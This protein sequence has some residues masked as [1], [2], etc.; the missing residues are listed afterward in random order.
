MGSLHCKIRKNGGSKELHVSAGREATLN[1]ALHNKLQQGRPSTLL[2]YGTSMS[3]GAQITFDITRMETLSTFLKRGV[4]GDQLRFVMGQVKKLIDDCV[5]AGLPLMNLILDDK[6]VFNDSWKERVAFVYVPLSG[7]QPDIKLMRNFFANL[8]KKAKPADDDAK[9][10]LDAYNAFFAE[11][12]AFNPTAYAKNLGLILVKNGASPSILKRSEAGNDRATNPIEGEDGDS[13]D[14]CGK[15]AQGPGTTVLDEGQFDGPEAVSPEQVPVAAADSAASSVAAQVPMSASV[16]NGAVEPEAARTSAANKE[17]VVDQDISLKGKHSIGNVI[18]SIAKHT[19]SNSKATGEADLAAGDDSEPEGQQ[20]RLSD[21]NS[22]VNCAADDN[23]TTVL[24]ASSAAEAEDAS[25]AA[26]DADS[27]PEADDTDTTL[28]GKSPFEEPVVE[29]DA[30]D[31]GVDAA[32]Q[33]EAADGADVADEADAASDHAAMSTEADGGDG[34]EGPADGDAAKGVEPDEEPGEGAEPD[35]GASVVE[36]ANDASDETP[37]ETTDAAAGTIVLDEEPA[38]Q[39]PETLA[40][41][42]GTITLGA[43]VPG[44][45]DKPAEGGKHSSGENITNESGQLPWH[46][47]HANLDPNTGVLGVGPWQ[48]ICLDDEDDSVWNEEPAA[49][50]EAESEGAPQADDASVVETVAE[51]EPEPELEPEPEPTADQDSDTEAKSAVEEPSQADES[52]DNGDEEK[53]ESGANSKSIADE[54]EPECEP[55]PTADS[56][57]EPAANSGVKSD[58]GTEQHPEAEA[59]AEP[60]P[61]AAS[62]PNPEPE[63]EPDSEAV[64]EPKK[65]AAADQAPVQDSPAAPSAPDAPA[66]PAK[67]AADT[68]KNESRKRPALDI[69]ELPKTHWLTHEGSGERVRIQ[70]KRFVV[71]KSKYS[72]YQVRNT[73]TVSRSHALFHCEEDGCWIEDDNSRNGTFVNGERLAPG[74]RKRLSDGDSVRMSDEMFTFG[75]R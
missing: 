1:E 29:D 37:D 23:D 15:P 4:T 50:A 71:G 14:R 20:G 16:G 61:A 34:T 22:R 72:N 3:S 5:S 8:L 21:L 18:A 36:A 45:A 24:G 60:E 49:D 26:P 28:L 42:G 52:A 65:E 55:K 40:D 39:T 43:D 70:G 62:K 44:F 56:E 46:A 63:P 12:A 57:T 13:A 17:P 47:R 48:T 59:A 11:N 25:D 27:Q 51:P 68:G 75:E 66:S 54:S 32:G 9:A 10:L 64:T 41:D 53:V 69:P 35:A 73:T 30:S 38:G 74:V 31:V 7:I 2:G 58:S 6:Y 19:A 33:T 67:P